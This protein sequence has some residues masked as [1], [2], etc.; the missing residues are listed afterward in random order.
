MDG[1]MLGV[2][3]YIMQR[4]GYVRTWSIRRDINNEFYMLILNHIDGTTTRHAVLGDDTIQ[5]IQVTIFP[6]TNHS[7]KDVRDYT[8]ERTHMVTIHLLRIPPRVK[9][10]MMATT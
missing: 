1:T 6:H 9:C 2:C 3:R 8:V 7:D 10:R 5:N 4:G